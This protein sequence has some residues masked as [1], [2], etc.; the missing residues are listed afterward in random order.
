MT[1]IE[2]T[3]SVVADKQL[4]VIKGWEARLGTLLDGTLDHEKGDPNYGWAMH[5]DSLITRHANR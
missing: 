3:V 1:L 2:P 5:D 4:N